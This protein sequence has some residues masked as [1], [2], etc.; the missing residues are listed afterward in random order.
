MKLSG[1]KRSTSA[2]NTD[3]NVKRYKQSTIHQELEDWSNEFNESI[4][5]LNNDSSKSCDLVCR[6]R[7][8]LAGYSR[9]EISSISSEFEYIPAFVKRFTICKGFKRFGIRVHVFEPEAMKKGELVPHDHQKSFFSTNVVGSYYHSKYILKDGNGELFSRKRVQGS[10]FE[11]E[12]SACNNKEL[13]LVCNDKFTPRAGCYYLPSDSLHS[14]KPVETKEESLITIVVRLLDNSKESATFYSSN[15]DELNSVSFATSPQKI[16]SEKAQED[17]VSKLMKHLS[18]HGTG[19]MEELA[20]SV[21]E[22]S[23]GS[24][25]FTDLERQTHDFLQECFNREQSGQNFP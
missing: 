14:I 9:E 12:I 5:F 10:S 11:S 8:L 19:V 24:V 2:A 17:L 13:K 21:V 6:L 15:F 3:D 1:S 20:G 16:C 4:Q 22:E 23:A 18:S 25:E 7:E